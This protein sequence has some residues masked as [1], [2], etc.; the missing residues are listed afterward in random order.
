MCPVR[1]VTY[2]SGRSVHIQAMRL[3]RRYRDPRRHEPDPMAALWVHH[4][5][6]PVEVEKH[7]EGRVACLRHAIQLSY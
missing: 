2:V 5:N 7:I 6:L 4:E 3:L 1:T